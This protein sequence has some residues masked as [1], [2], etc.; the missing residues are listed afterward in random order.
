[1]MLISMSFHSIMDQSEVM[2]L[3]VGELVVDAQFDLP[4]LE[5]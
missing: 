2:I 5:P 4:L 3:R 1:M